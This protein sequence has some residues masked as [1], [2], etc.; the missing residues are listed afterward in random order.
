MG[1]G[2]RS[3]LDFNATSQNLSCWPVFFKKGREDDSLKFY[4]TPC[5]KTEL[6]DLNNKHVLVLKM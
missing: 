1:D 5:A 6:D 4:K 3:V 2:G